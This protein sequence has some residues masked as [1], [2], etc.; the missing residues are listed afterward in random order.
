MGAPTALQLN[1]AFSENAAAFS[2]EPGE[3]NTT[4]FPQQCGSGNQVGVART[5]WYTIQGTGRPMTV[6]TDG[7]DFDSA[8][9]VYTGSPAGGLVDCSDDAGGG[10]NA[11]VEFASAAGTTYHLQVGRA[12]NAG[13]QSPCS[14][15]PASGVVTIKASGTAATPPPS[16]GSPPPAYGG[17][18][19]PPAAGSGGDSSAN[20]PA[21]AVPALRTSTS[22]SVVFSG[23]STRFTKL[24]VAGA[25]AGASVLVSCK[26]KKGCPFKSRTLAVKKA[27]TVSLG[28]LFK[29]AKLRSKTLVTI[30]VTR[31]GFIGNVF[32]YTLRKRKPPLRT[33][34]CLAPGASKP[35]AT[36]S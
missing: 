28:K 15:S 36:C 27:G 21:T 1:T 29:S 33:T 32:T 23:A 18:A 14:Q 8:L 13:P 6:S 22:S 10:T 34:Q 16:G 24:N 3:Q 25:P 5:A 4:A 2:V 9:F 35:Q 12:C 11:I 19:P 17:A 7:S 31:P 26:A 20:G 30:R